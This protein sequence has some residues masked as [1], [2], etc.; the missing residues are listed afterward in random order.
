ME[1]DLKTYE[2]DLNKITAEKER[3]SAELNLATNIQADA[4]PSK[5]PVFTERKEFE[6]YA[7]MTPAKEV[8]GDFYDFFLIDNN[9]LGLVMADV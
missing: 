1:K 6:I 3:I 8:G 5:F 2:K 7:K 9:H 4:L